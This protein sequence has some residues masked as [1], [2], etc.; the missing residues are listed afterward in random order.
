MRLNAY[1]LAGDPAWATQSLRSYYDLV[2]LVVVSFDRSHR[3]WAGHPLEVPE[4]IEALRAA[5]P[6]GKIRLLAGDWSHP[7]R[8]VLEVETEQR[9]A[10]FEAAAGSA[11]WVLQLDTDEILLSRTAFVT[12]LEEADRRGAE[13]LAYP[14]R[15]FYQEAGRGRFLERCGRFWTTQSGYPGP[16][17]VKSTGSLSHCRQAAVP[18]YRVDV[19]PWNADPAHPASA[20]VHGVVRPDEAVAHLSWV[21]TPEQMRAKALTSGY[22]PEVNWPREVRRWSWRG[23]HPYVASAV[24]LFASS[25]FGHFRITKLDV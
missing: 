11:D 5:D 15:N 19:R 2:D 16:L 21:R 22:A 7:D 1:V 17:A 6:Q 3:S 24:G 25:P 8:P 18:T 13:A 10:A 14:L 12:H 9:Q 23:R 20:R 4:A